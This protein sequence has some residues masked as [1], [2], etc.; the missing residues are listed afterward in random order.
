MNFKAR[1]DPLVVVPIPVII[2]EKPLVRL[3]LIPVTTSKEV[4]G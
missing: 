4:F 1:F 3:V 2:P